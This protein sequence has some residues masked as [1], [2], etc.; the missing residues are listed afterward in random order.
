MTEFITSHTRICA[1]ITSTYLYTYLFIYNLNKYRS[2][3]NC[4]VLL[5]I[6]FGY[7]LSHNH[8]P[9]LTTSTQSPLSWKIFSSNQYLLKNAG[10]Y[11]NLYSPGLPFQFTGRNISLQNK[12]QPVRHHNHAPFAV[13]CATG[14]VPRLTHVA[15]D[16]TFLATNHSGARAQAPPKTEGF[17]K[18]GSVK[19]FH[20]VR[21]AFS[22]QACARVESRLLYL[23]S[24]QHR[25]RS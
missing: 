11:L 9:Y 6:F 25:R 17:S 15:V 14:S 12:G 19:T 20:W 3:G 24:T 13:A 16:L 10:C 22:S 8:C 2:V 4:I 18:C 23:Q 21:V 5:F 7:H 1:F